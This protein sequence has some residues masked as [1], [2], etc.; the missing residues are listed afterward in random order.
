VQTLTQCNTVGSCN[1]TFT[2]YYTFVRSFVHSFIHSFI[3]PYTY[4]SQ[5]MYRTST[6]FLP[7]DAM[8]K[9]G[10]YSRPVSV[11]LS[12]SHVGGLYPNGWRYRQTSYAAR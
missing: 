4:T 1:T 10:H 7:R 11:R 12:V 9:R 8:R 5:L 6:R 2:T 3:H